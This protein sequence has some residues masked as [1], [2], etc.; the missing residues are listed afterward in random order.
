MPRSTQA[1]DPCLAI[2]APGLARGTLASKAIEP[3]SIPAASVSPRTLVTR[4]DHGGGEIAGDNDESWSQVVMTER[5]LT[6]V[7]P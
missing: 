7:L 4:P 3:I 5:C 6:I 2:G 1:I